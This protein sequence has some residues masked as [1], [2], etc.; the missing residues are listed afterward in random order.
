MSVNVPSN[1]P[2]SPESREDATGEPRTKGEPAS[3]AVPPDTSPAEHDLSP[4]R[5]GRAWAIL[6]GVTVLGLVIDLATKYW[7]F[8][9]LAGDPVQVSREAVLAARGRLGGLIPYHEPT[10]VVPY[11]LE[12]KLVLNPGAVFGMGAG[13][14]WFFVSFTIAAVGF[15]LWLFSTWTRARDA[16]L[17]AAMGL[18]LAGGIGNLYDRLKFACVR[19]FL[20]PLPGVEL[21]F[22]WRLPWGGTEIWPYVSNVADAFLLIGIGILIMVTWRRGEPA[23][24]APAGPSRAG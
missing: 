9:T 10:V 18:I 16:W 3:S 2:A 15:V 17:H 24:V 12:L 19:D 11:L 8:G 21:P 20:H 22:G 5:S 23:R 14:R 6:L 1:T 13:K 4:L 7:A